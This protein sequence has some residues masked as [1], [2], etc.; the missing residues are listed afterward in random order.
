MALRFTENTSPAARLNLTL[1]PRAQMAAVATVDW[2]HVNDKPDF[3]DLVAG[4]YV[5]YDEDQPLTSD[6]ATQARDNI[7]VGDAIAAAAVRYDI[8][9]SLNLTQRERIRQNI[10]GERAAGYVVTPEMFLSTAGG[11]VDFDDAAF[12]AMAAEFVDA[13]EPVTFELPGH[14]KVADRQLFS[15]NNI[16]LDGRG[17]GLIDASAA[18]L[19]DT[20]GIFAFGNDSGLGTRTTMTVDAAAGATTITVNDAALYSPGTRI[21]ITSTGEYWGGITGVSGFAPRNKGE[22]SVVQSKSGSVLTLARPLRESYAATTYTTYVRPLTVRENIS[23]RGLRFLGPGGGTDHTSSNPTGVRA[24]EATL[25]DGLS[26]DNCFFENFPRY[27]VDCN[28]GYGLKVRGITGIGRKLDDPTNLPSISPWFT[29]IASQGV[30]GVEVAHSSAHYARRL[31][32]GIESNFEFFDADSSQSITGGD[33]TI[34][35][36]ESIKCVTGPTGHKY[37]GMQVFG[38]TMLG[39]TFGLHHRGKNFTA[40]GNVIK[41]SELGIVIGSNSSEDASAYSEDPRHGRV[42][43][44]GNVVEATGTGLKVGTSFDYLEVI[45]GKIE[46]PRPIRFYS[47]GRSNFVF[48]A[49]VVG[50]STNPG[51]DSMDSL[52][53][54]ASNWKIG[55]IIRNVTRGWVHRGAVATTSDIVCDGA[56]FR[57]ISTTMVARIDDFGGATP[58]FGDNIQIINCTGPADATIGLNLAQFPIV[59]VKNNTW[60]DGPTDVASAATIN[61]LRNPSEFLNLTGTTTISSFG[62]GR[63][64]IEKKLLAA[65]GLTLTHSAN[66]LCPGAVDLILAAGEMA[67]VVCISSSVW[68]VTRFGGLSRT[69]KS[70]PFSGGVAVTSESLGTLASGNYDVNVGLGPLQHGTV[71]AATNFRPGSNKG[72]TTLEVTLSGGS[73]APSDSTFTKSSG[74]PWTTT[75]GHVFKVSIYIGNGYSSIHREQ[76]V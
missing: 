45:G 28:V 20:H 41:G 37:D 23:I 21:A 10:Y 2:A 26:I 17:R 30:Q 57:D 16:A 48:D 50:D 22:L 62:T 55:G 15:I 6:Q 8:S 51:I 69:Q 74:E 36:G 49:E 3:V 67:L 46:A 68:R 40:V 14:Y 1:N 9:Q 18:S 33:I 59:R 29:I 75:S 24:I 42:I 27:A 64:G 43:L 76:L 31:F 38:H 44:H 11:G 73:A 12:A 56:H 61:L 35:G 65:S 58:T 13:D 19:S 5:R 60:T 25:F 34:V 39:C 7:G 47:K 53:A 70:Q 32:D 52:A 4:S 66:L 54:D 63:A 71:N 72:F